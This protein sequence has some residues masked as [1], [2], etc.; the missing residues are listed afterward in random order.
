M[1]GWRLA[2]NKGNKPCSDASAPGMLHRLESLCSRG[3]IKV[4]PCGWTVDAVV[5]HPPSTTG[6]RK[7]QWADLQFVLDMLTAGADPVP[8]YA[9]ADEAVRQDERVSMAQ[10]QAALAVSTSDSDE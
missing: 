3:R 9:M 10:L 5:H 4:D 6:A 7:E 8:T 2:S 1:S